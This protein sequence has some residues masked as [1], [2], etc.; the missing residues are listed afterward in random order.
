MESGK[1][2][3]REERRRR[4][5]GDREEK[6]EIDSGGGECNGSLNSMH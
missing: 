6:A 3:G 2:R 1:V 5:D 4:R